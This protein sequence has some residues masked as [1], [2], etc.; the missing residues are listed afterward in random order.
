MS[1]KL[2]IST[3]L[4]LAV[5]FQ[6]CSVKPDLFLRKTAETQIV[7]ATKINVNVMWQVNWNV[8][9]TYPWD[10]AVYGPVGYTV[11]ASMRL[12]IYPHG[13][14]GKVQSH[15]VFNFYGTSTELPIV[16]GT[17]DLIFHNNDS[18][19]LLF[20]TDGDLGD[21][22]C[23]T[24]TIS[25]GLKE[26]SPVKTI[27]QK[28]L[29]KGEV[30]APESEPVV[31]MPDGLFVLNDMGHVITDNLDE[32]DY[33]DGKYV[34]HISGELDPGT[35]IYLFQVHL[36][37]NNGR[38]VGSNGGGVITGVAAGVTLNSMMADEATVSVPM[39]VHYDASGDLLGARVVCFGI[40]GCNAYEKESVTKA[41][42]GNNCLV[43]NITYNN[44]TW[45]NICIDVS[46]Q[47]RS[48]PTGGVIDLELDVDDFPPE[49]G[50]SSG[51]GFDAL[52]DS[53]KEEQAETVL[54]N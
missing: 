32:Y 12:H 49:G 9:W 21:I 53:W 15:Q 42:D 54:I 6:G 44:G 47:V 10:A 2:L 24:R 23:Y 28:A 31:L 26:S 39:D 4:A 1:R 40:P 7:L 33:I 11:P 19:V 29:T 45:K 30:K 38:V 46:S 25:G 50:S 52:I 22:Y 17:Y 34:L 48:L 13:A 16:V 8:V 36:L 43:L 14:D 3:L 5:L 35:F 51:S 27:Q 20:K 18:E 41:P 37:N